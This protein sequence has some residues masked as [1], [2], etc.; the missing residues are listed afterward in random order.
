VASDEKERGINAE[1]TE[2]AEG[3]EKKE[4]K[5]QKRTTAR[6][7]PVF[8]TKIAGKQTTRKT[9]HYKKKEPARMPALQRRTI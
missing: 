7:E 6:K 9:G 5:S 8:P 2:R 1:N 4:E 3:T